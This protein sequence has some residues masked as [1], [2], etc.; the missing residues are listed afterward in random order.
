MTRQ[1]DK[2]K[3]SSY[4]THS[5][6]EPVE[7]SQGHGADYLC[8]LSTGSRI[9]WDRVLYTLRPLDRLEEREPLP[10][11]PLDR[12]EERTLYFQSFCDL[13]TGSRSDLLKKAY[14]L[15]LRRFTLDNFA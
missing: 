14:F 1:K 3:N 15:Y 12:L 2:E 7:R 6:L 8:D 5:I 9:E 11:R 4:K 13:S 10:L